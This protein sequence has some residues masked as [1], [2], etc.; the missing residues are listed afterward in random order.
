MVAALRAALGATLV[1]ALGAALGAFGFFEG[2]CAEFLVTAA[3]GACVVTCV[4]SVDMV[5]VVV[6]AA[7]EV[8][9]PG[10]GLMTLLVASSVC[11]S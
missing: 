9:A 7:G 2:A 8:A 11:S 6:P 10:V 3:V 5:G 1:A 4:V